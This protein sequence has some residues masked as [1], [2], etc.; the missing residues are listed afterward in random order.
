MHKQQDDTKGSNIMNNPMHPGEF[1][2]LAYMEPLNIS[3]TELAERLDVSPSSLSRIIN[4]KMD[5]S[6]DMAVKLSKVLGRSAESWI[7]IQMAYSLSEAKKK[8]D[9]SRLQPIHDLV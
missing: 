5:V 9:E 7:N 1:I 4:K 6:C 2:F 3:A 8:I